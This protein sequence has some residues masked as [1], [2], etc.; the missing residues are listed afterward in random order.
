MGPSDAHRVSVCVCARVCVSPL[1]ES[2]YVGTKRERE[3]EEKKACDWIIC[4]TLSVC[5]RIRTCMLSKLLGDG[6]T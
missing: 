6:P 2:V 4:V 1:G 5:A 3:E